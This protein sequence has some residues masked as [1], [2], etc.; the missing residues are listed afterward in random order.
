MHKVI[1]MDVSDLHS[2]C[3]YLYCIGCIDIH[4][5]IAFI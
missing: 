2:K 5:E 4:P 3:C 1:A